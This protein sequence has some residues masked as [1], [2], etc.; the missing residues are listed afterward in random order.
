MLYHTVQKL[1]KGL[2]KQTFSGR[3]HDLK[4][5]CTLYYLLCRRKPGIQPPYGVVH[6]GGGTCSLNIASINAFLVNSLI[7]ARY[8]RPQLSSDVTHRSGVF[9]AYYTR[10]RGLSGNRLPRFATHVS[11]SKKKERSQSNSSRFFSAN[12]SQVTTFS[13]MFLR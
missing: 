10:I 7:A 8:R 13:N 3:I 2:R 12:V 9:T 4:A 5:L 6:T 1:I 11:N